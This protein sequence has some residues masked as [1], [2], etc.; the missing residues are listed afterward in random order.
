M[1]TTSLGCQILQRHMFSLYTFKSTPCHGWSRSLMQSILWTNKLT[2]N[3]CYCILLLCKLLLLIIIIPVLRNTG[4]HWQHNYKWCLLLM[5]EKVFL[6]TSDTN[7]SM[8]V[9]LWTNPACWIYEVNLNWHI[10]DA[11]TTRKWSWQ[12][13]DYQWIVFFIHMDDM[14]TWGVNVNQMQWQKNTSLKGFGIQ[15]ITNLQEAFKMPIPK[16]SLKITLLKLQPKLPRNNELIYIHNT[17]PSLTVFDYN[18]NTWI[19]L[20]WFI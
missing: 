2:R 20:S 13:W 16:M 8:I 18:R 1:S 11:Y 10:L 4:P 12:W 6:I 19:L 17:K 5:M 7:T 9:Y 3:G 14:S 15:P